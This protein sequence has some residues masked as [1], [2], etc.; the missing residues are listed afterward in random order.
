MLSFLF[1]QIKFVRSYLQK[2][3][4]IDRPTFIILFNKQL[5]IKLFRNIF[6]QKL[7]LHKSCNYYLYIKEKVSLCVVK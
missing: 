2:I 4:F 7:D 6:T 3:I 5:H 1:V